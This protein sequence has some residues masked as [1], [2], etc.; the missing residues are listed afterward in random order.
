MFRDAERPLY[1]T[2]ANLFKG[3]AHPYRIKVLE[4][5]STHSEASVADMVES[6]GLEHSHLSQH[7]AVL[8]RHGLVTSQR[9]ASIVFYRLANPEVAD[10]LR[11]ARKLLT[12]MLATSQ[13]QQVALEDLPE[14]PASAGAQSPAPHSSSEPKEFS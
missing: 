2:K 5:L 14:I 6:T 8:R 10:L 9:R 7:L 3:L 11:V 13:E 4:I 12:G 1:E